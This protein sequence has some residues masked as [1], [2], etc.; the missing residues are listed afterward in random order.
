M[1]FGFL[2]SYI[3]NPYLRA[4]VI[5]IGVFIILKLFVFIVEKI[6]SR[7]TKKTKTNLDDIIVSKSSKPISIILI[8]IGLRLALNEFNIAQRVQEIMQNLIYSAIIVFAGY[9]VYVI[10]DNFLNVFWKKLSKKTKSDLDDSL[11][12]LVHS[13]LKAAWIVFVLLYILDLWGIQ[14]GP[15]LAGLGIGG[16]AIAFALQESLSNIFGGISVI[17]DKTIKVGDVVYVKDDIKGEVLNVGLRSTKVRNWD[18]EVI[19]VPNSI[20]ANSKIQNLGQPEL[21]SR[22]VINFGVAYG[23]D[24]NKVKKIVLGELKKIK[25]VSKEP[26]P[27]VR[28]MNMGD[29]ALEFVAQF[30]VDSFEFRIGAIDEANTKIYN[31]LNKNG[32]EIPFPQMDVHVKK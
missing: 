15:F 30:H 22:V 27:V 14:I 19:I 1:T 2:D 28:F 4:L 17:I 11:S 21:K 3:A 24:I 32:I 13:I 29:S 23:S 16:I 26:E 8:L 20:I 18:N 10:I 31:A 25:N 6:I 5:V 9:V 12:S 7:F